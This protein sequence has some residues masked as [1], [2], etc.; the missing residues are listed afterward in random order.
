VSALPGAVAEA[1]HAHRSAHGRTAVVCST[2]LASHQLL[3]ARVPAEA[4]DAFRERLLGPLV[5]YD[6]AHD[7][8]LVRTLAEFLECGGSWSRCAERLHVHVNTLRYR[9]SRVESLTGRDLTRFEDR[10]DFFLALRLSR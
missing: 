4:R 5:A 2:E 9:I 1:R 6:E 7:A 8:D 3:L 10:V